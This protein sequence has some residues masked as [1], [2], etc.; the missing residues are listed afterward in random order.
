MLWYIDW[1]KGPGLP[2][3]LDISDL[4]EIKDSDRLFARKFDL[5]ID[6]NLLYNLSSNNAL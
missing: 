5:D 3:I 4:E 1:K 6:K 2:R